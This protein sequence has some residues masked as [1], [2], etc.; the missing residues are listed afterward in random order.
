MVD[1]AGRAMTP[2]HAVKGKVR[3][4]YYITR[5]DLVDEAKAWR[6]S[7][8]DLERLVGERIASFL[9]DQSELM[10]QLGKA[11]DRCAGHCCAP[12]I[13]APGS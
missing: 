13:G 6:V 10:G 2:S 8:H 9:A 5:P 7:G 12:A 4:R 3:Y 11:G 1:G